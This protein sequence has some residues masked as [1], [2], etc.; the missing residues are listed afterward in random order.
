MSATNA[1]RQRQ[2]RQRAKADGLVRLQMFIEADI[3]EA[4]GNLARKLKV[5]RYAI[6]EH[7]VKELS[8]RYP[9]A[10][11]AQKR[12]S[13]GETYKTIAED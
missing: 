7:A 3:D 12:L 2:Y 4:I 8:K 6:I 11:N 13:Q 9:L 10:E 5:P 1:E